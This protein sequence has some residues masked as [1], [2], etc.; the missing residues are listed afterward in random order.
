MDGADVIVIATEWPE[1]RDLP[2]ADWAAAPD[3]PLVVDGRR[4][5]DAGSMRALGWR[6]VQL[7]DGRDRDRPVAAASIRRAEAS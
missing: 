2:W 3:R 7:G 4:L 6:F 5:L 1:F